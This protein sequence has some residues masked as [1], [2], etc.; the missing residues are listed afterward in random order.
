MPSRFAFDRAYYER[1]YRNPRTRIGGPREID[2]L[3]DLVAAYLRYLRQP[4]RTVLDFGCGLGHWRGAVERLFPRA[5]YTGIEV[6]AYLCE[7]YG[8]Q[9]GS[10]VDW[11]AE[12][13]AD[14]VICQGVLQYLTAAEAE[15]AIANLARNCRGALLLEVLTRED[16]EHNCDR[17]RTDGAVFLRPTAWYRRR[18]RPLFTAAGGGLFLRPDS[19]AVL[20][21]L[22][23]CR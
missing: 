22:E 5:R 21:E 1:H 19:R 15:R 13:P 10:V 8:W 17:E 12:R 20:W 23:V 6:S 16:W 3:G 7:R 4:V 2:R 11:V 14:L 9:R 18:L